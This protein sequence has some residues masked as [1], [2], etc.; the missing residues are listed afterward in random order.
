MDSFSCYTAASND[1]SGEHIGQFCR[2]EIETTKMA[3]VCFGICITGTLQGMFV[4]FVV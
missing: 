3:G 2:R 1:V 4:S